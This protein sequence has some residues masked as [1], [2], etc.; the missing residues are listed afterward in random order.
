MAGALASFLEAAS[1]GVLNDVLST[2]HSDSGYAIPNRFD[3][4]ITPPS[5]VQLDARAVSLRCES[6]T[7]PGRNLVSK[8]DNMAY[9]PGRE[10]VTGAGYAGTINMNFQASSGLDERIFFEEWQKQAF[11]EQTW[12]V[13]YYNDYTGV[14]DMYILDR[15]DKRRYGVRLHECYPKD[16]AGTELGQDQ[17]DQIIKNTVTFQYHHWT[18]LD[19]NRQPPNLGNQILST[20]IN[21]ATRTILSN[22]PSILNRLR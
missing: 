13:G 2:F 20:L 18:V 16:I 17:N 7:L 21:T 6:V 4:I 19:R 9:G 1:F 11:D 12:D 15:Q 5:V 10:V 3:V 8:P 14:I 22:V